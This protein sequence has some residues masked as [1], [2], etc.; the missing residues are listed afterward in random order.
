[1]KTKV[2]LVGAALAVTAVTASAETI[3]SSNVVG[4]VHL[5]LVAGWNL[6]A[7]PLDAGV[8]TLNNLMQGVPDGTQVF[9]MENGAW[10]AGS[11]YDAEFEEWSDDYTINPG[12]GMFVM[13]N[14][15]CTITFVGEVK[16]GAHSVE[17]PAGWSMAASPTP[18]AGTLADIGLMA[19]A[20]ND[21]DQVF[22]WNVDNKSFDSA[23]FDGEFEEWSS[24]QTI[25]V[26][27]SFLMKKSAAT[28]WTRN[29]EIK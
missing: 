16:A 27:Y 22:V 23:S 12:E 18:V 6:V 11:A 20:V 5:D 13:V 1:M 29:F 21:A 17:L 24:E 25:D 2:L 26:G 9:K 15:P 8:N 3:Y 10:N 19:P 14:E 4:Y 7:N 28:T